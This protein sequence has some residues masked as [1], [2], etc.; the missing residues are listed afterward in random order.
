MGD[1]EYQSKAGQGDFDDAVEASEEAAREAAAELDID[2]QDVETIARAATAA[3]QD[4]ID[5][6]N[7]RVLRAAAEL[8]N[9]RRRAEREKADAAKYAIANFAR[10]L[11][12]V[13]DNF[14]RAVASA[15]GEDAALNAET[16]KG[17]MTGILMT[18]KE[19][20]TV[21]ERHGVRKIDPQGEKFDPNMHQ[22]VAQAPAEGIPSGHV[23]Q[24]AQTGFVL[25]ERVLRAAMVIV[26]TGAPS[27]GSDDA[28]KNEAS[29][30][31]VGSDD[32]PYKDQ[33]DASPSVDTRA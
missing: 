15:P 12:P 2:D 10:D 26:S 32:S 30:D 3:L 4:E 24:T 23:A 6:L 17:L 13:A 27:A 11:L 22:A 18:E 9:T 31:E 25:G 19:L 14:E 21:L 8:E 1:N 29:R 5:K 16:L 7:D 33:S 20:L 28:G